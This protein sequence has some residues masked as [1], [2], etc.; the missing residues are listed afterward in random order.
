MRNNWPYFIVASFLNTLLVTGAFI[1]FK[2]R[3][4]AVIDQ[5]PGS[6]WRD[7]DPFQFAS[8]MFVLSFLVIVAIIGI[9]DLVTRIISKLHSFNESLATTQPTASQF[10]IDNGQ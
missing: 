3:G 5:Q 8:C 1:E 10:A 6:V 7:I 2:L 4:I 9:K